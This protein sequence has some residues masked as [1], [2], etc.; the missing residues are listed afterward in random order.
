MKR[1][2]I[3]FI[4]LPITIGNMI[5][6]QT[7][8][9]GGTPLTGN[10]GIQGI[11]PNSL[12]FQLTYDYNFLNDLYSGTQSLEDNKRER[13]TQTI[14]FQGIY[15]FSDKF[16]VNTLF[17]YVSQQRRIFS[18]I[19]APNVTK[20]KGVG[21]VVVLV[22]YTPFSTIKR[23]LTMALGPKLPIGKFNATDPEFGIVLSPDLQ[24]G[25]G[26]LD[27]ILGASYQEYHLL[28]V[29]GFTLSG[30]AGYRLTTPAKRFEGD[31]NYR[32][33]NETMLSLGIQK[34]IL[35]KKSRITPSV[36]IRYRNT[37]SDKI[38]GSKV[39][40]TGGNWMYI[41][42]GIGIDLF[43]NLSINASGGLPV[44]RNL[45]G[46]QL[47]TAYRFNAGITYKIVRN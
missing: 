37:L 16:S 11:E 14:L 12:Y 7:C 21:D 13:L 19:G 23:S 8:C 3:L 1:F 9:S 45:N 47:T 26:S 40:G 29:P 44:Y 42:P 39:A 34:S 20:T 31:N 35:V 15:S 38:N 33:G 10:L 24:P 32:F 36:F 6:G 43:S 4:V 27:G 25:S 41:N 2:G 5:Y 22:Q 18:R 17:T 30:S 28:N 46:T